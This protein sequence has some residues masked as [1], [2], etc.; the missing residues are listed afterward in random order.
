MYN[1]KTVSVVISTYRE[2]FSLIQFVFSHKKHL[3]NP[4]LSDYYFD[5][6]IEDFEYREIDK[7]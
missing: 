5:V 1:K 6:S 2:I 3:P 7:L 4:Y